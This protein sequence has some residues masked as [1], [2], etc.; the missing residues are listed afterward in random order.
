MLFAQTNNPL[1]SDVQNCAKADI[2]VGPATCKPPMPK[3]PHNLPDPKS[4]TAHHS[5]SAENPLLPL[6]Q[7]R[8][9]STSVRNLRL[10]QEPVPTVPACFS[11]RPTWTQAPRCMQPFFVKMGLLNALMQHWPAN[12]CIEV[13]VS[14]AFRD[15]SKTTELTTTHASRGQ[16]KAKILPVMRVK[17]RGRLKDFEGEEWRGSAGLKQQELYG[18]MSRAFMKSASVT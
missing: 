4:R 11:P 6:T 12:G 17:S 18:R 13:L 14:T 7:A 10:P 15:I 9:M 8:P 1:L 3:T 16:Q 5:H 2:P